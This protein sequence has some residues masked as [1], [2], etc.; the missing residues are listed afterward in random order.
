MRGLLP[1]LP[2]FPVARAGR[3]VQAQSPVTLN[4]KGRLA[5]KRRSTVSPR[6]WGCASIHACSVSPVAATTDG[7]LG[8][9]PILGGT[10]GGAWGGVKP[11]QG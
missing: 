7:Q 1:S 9:V 11:A 3:G 8:W 4:R 10:H 5:P 6:L 2:E